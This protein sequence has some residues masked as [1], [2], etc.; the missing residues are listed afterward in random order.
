M[1]GT[2]SFGRHAGESGIEE[3]AHAKRIELRQNKSL[4]YLGKGLSATWTSIPP[5]VRKHID[6][7]H[8]HNLCC[9]EKR[10]R[11]QGETLDGR[12]DQGEK[13]TAQTPV[14]PATSCKMPRLRA[15][16]ASQSTWRLNGRE[17]KMPSLKQI[18]FFRLRH[19]CVLAND[20]KLQMTL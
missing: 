4:L 2:A 8:L 17:T 11:G 13:G 10:A 5:R 1:H 18:M 19:E 9:E 16:L 3:G 12:S 14:H 20:S 6:P 15:I 7:A